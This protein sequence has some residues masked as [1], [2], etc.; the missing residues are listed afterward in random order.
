[1]Q[2][3]TLYLPAVS[4][5]LLVKNKH[6]NL[7]PQHFKKVTSQQKLFKIAKKKFQNECILGV[8]TPK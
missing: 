6:N 7:A 2:K 3:E 5:L 4:S 8:C 1:M